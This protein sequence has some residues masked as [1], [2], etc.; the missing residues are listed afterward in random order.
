MLMRYV[1]LLKVNG[2]KKMANKPL[3]PASTLPSRRLRSSRST[4]TG[5]CKQRA[6]RRVSTR[7]NASRLSG[8]LNGPII[9]HFHC[10]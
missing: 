1:L 4:T 6:G 9:L 8:A 2:I 10:F 5:Q 7:L 3:E